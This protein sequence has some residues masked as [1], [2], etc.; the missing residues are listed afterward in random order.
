VECCR[1]KQLE[2]L[3]QNSTHRNN[4]R[5]EYEEINSSRIKE[6]NAAWVKNNHDKHYKNCLEWK[7]R[8]PEKFALS[9]QLSNQKNAAR[10]KARTIKWAKD[11]PA[12]RAATIA[13]WAEA[14]PENRRAAQA[15]RR[16][17]TMHSLDNFT[18]DDV[19]ELYGA[20][21]GRCVYCQ[22]DLSREYHIDHIMPL[23]LGGGNS[24]EN[25][26]L[27]C[28]PCNLSKGKKHPIDFARKKLGTL[29]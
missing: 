14:H 18:K 5:A 24:R 25:I 16:A 20:Q 27:T 28:K 9:V 13:A 3:E 22:A 15:K 6:R 10:I 4:W 7:E 11:N 19:L 12:R 8:N 17:R 2:W 23:A 1:I 21:R 26:Q 29:L